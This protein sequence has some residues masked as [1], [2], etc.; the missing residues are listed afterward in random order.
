MST[1]RTTEMLN[2]LSAI[3]REVGAFRQEVKDR[4]D[5]INGH[6]GEVNGRFDRLETEMR[7]GFAAV[8]ADIRRLKQQLDVITQDLMALRVDHRDHEARIAALEQKQA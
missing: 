3:A 4:F 7:E 2:Y 1:D 6:F 5:E 8:R